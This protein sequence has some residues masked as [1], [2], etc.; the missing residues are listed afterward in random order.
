MWDPIKGWPAISQT[1]CAQNSVK[2]PSVGSLVVG[3]S[4]CMALISPHMTT[5]GIKTMKTGPSMPPVALSLISLDN[6]YQTSGVAGAL[7]SCSEGRVLR[8]A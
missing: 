5:K 8:W 3:M 1:V 6:T 7:K 4:T 2:V